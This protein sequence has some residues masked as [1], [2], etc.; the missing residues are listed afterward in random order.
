MPAL[1]PV[2]LGALPAPL[3]PLV[4]REREVDQV[5][6]LLRRGGVRLLT[7]TGP[8]GVGKT[9][10]A[11]RIAT[12][13]AGEFADGASFV[14]LA[15]V[16]DPALVAAAIAAAVRVRD[17]GGRQLDEC[18]RDA[19]RDRHLLLV[20]DNLEHVLDAAPLLTGL[21]AG[22]PGLVVLATSR[23]TLRL[24]GEHDVPVPP[25]PL[26]DPERL[27][28]AAPLLEIA[29][30]RLLAERARAVDASFALTADNAAA[31]AAVCLRLD[32]LPLAIEL[33]A[34]RSNLLSPG[35]LL[36]R[37]ARRLPL[38]TGGRRDA[39]TRHQTMRDAIAWSYDLLEPAEQRL[40]RQLAVFVG[41]CTLGAAEAVAG[42][43]AA[44][45]PFDGIGSL[46][47]KSLLRRFDAVAGDVR[48]GMLETVRELGLERLAASGEEATVRDAHAAYFLAL[49]VR[50]EPAL[51]GPE[52]A[53]W[54]DRLAAEHA[55]LREAL[56]WAIAQGAVEPA[57]R[58]TASLLGFW[59]V[60][61]HLGEGRRWAERA[62][63]LPGG[64]AP[65]LRA[66][67][68]TG[69]AGLATGQGAYAGAVP[70]LQEAL[71]TARGGGDATGEAAALEGLAVVARHRGDAERAAA[72]FEEVLGRRRAL[73]DAAGAA[74]T[75]TNLANLAF[76]R[77]DLARA[78]GLYTEALASHRQAEDVG[79]MAAVLANLGLVAM[80][81]DEPDRAA[82]YLAEAEALGRSL[83]NERGVASVLLH[84]GWLAI[85][86]GEWAAAADLTRGALSRTWALGARRDVVEALDNLAYAATRQGRRERA[87]R[88]MAAA[89]WM[90]TDLGVAVDPVDQDIYAQE[91]AGLRDALGDAAFA[92]LWEAGRLRPP[93]AAVAEAMADGDPP[94]APGRPIGPPAE[95]PAAFH[96]TPRE[97]EVLRL[98][99]AGLTDREIANRL[100]IG[101]RTAQ[102][103]VSHVIGKLGAANRAE[104]AAVAVRER[105]V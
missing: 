79:G 11:L 68:L 54:L 30:V 92:A 98:V 63:A 51:R 27:S 21:L 29:A 22:C 78:V 60:R 67:V 88:L 69:A 33:A 85:L 25:L 38:L 65:A 34:A 46:T 73:G 61:G 97:V 23:A 80:R 55:D 37:L 91:V 39:P 17:E 70:L 62:L 35:E 13:L 83:G 47:E 71:D 7:L 52:Q 105:I 90:R 32:G 18:L 82:E 86:R 43:D 3:T 56:G 28:V 45:S 64:A 81:R 103:H 99:T 89:A 42:E 49:S 77:A 84:R 19:L 93:A 6:A 94:P 74:G 14:P 16:R 15:D 58:L 1:P 53:A 41:G 76:D 101:H 104:A 95:V 4:G 31:V 44:P 36:P 50:A 75:L 12:D 5:C 40:F 24:S 72:L 102:D 87:V 57:L 2:P 100:S 48:V 10:L 26:P 59:A 20:V 8:G 9:R 96:L 66:R